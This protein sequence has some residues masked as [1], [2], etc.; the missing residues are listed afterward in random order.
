MRR[1]LVLR[2]HRMLAVHVDRRVVLRQIRVVEPIAAHVFALPPLRQPREVLAQAI[3]EIAR[4]H[5]HHAARDPGLERAA[6]HRQRRLRPASQRRQQIVVRCDHGE[7]P[8]R[9]RLHEP[10][11]E[12]PERRLRRRLV[13]EPLAERRV[14]HHQPSLRR[15]P[16]ARHRVHLERDRLV[17]AGALRRRASELD[18]P[19][20]AI[21]P[22]DPPALHHAHA[23]TRFLD[24]GRPRLR[25][26]PEPTLESEALAQQPRRRRGGHERGLDRQRPR[27][28][29]RIHERA[30][31]LENVRPTGEA[32]QRRREVLLERRLALPDPIPAAMQALA[33]QIDRE[34]TPLAAHE[35]VHAQVGSIAIDVRPAPHRLAHAIDD[36][37]LHLLRA[38]LRV[39]DPR[40]R[41]DEV[42]RD[43]AL[44]P[45]M[46]LPRD[47]AHRAIE[48]V[49]IGGHDL[50]EP[51]QHPAR[52]PRADADPISERQR[53][54]HAAPARLLAHRA[55]A[56]LHQ[57]VAPQ[58]HKP[59]RRGGEVAMDHDARFQRRT[60]GRSS[61][62]QNARDSSMTSS[63]SHFAPTSPL[64][65]C[66]SNAHRPGSG[67]TSLPGPTLQNG[68]P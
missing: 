9:K 67:L 49:G 16:H 41:S 56:E 23:R 54:A 29:H 7:P 18:G 59:A 60:C 37:I 61:S 63:S 1:C 53:A 38:E 50:P 43:R 21:E 52:T 19:T 17:H 25:V 15:R 24:H 34:R 22:E 36:R 28:A 14:R 35:R 12:L 46:L 42:H 3:H 51:E 45:H 6:R 27:P 55:R 68:D 20:I 64:A 40:A 8:A 2:H 66:G 26:V 30:A 4:R 32:Q 65:M 11:A 44:G 31:A 48:A 39:L 33:R 10:I 13:A 57:L 62:S 5:L 58:P 47:L